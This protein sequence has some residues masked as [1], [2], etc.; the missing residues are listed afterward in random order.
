[1]LFAEQLHLLVEQTPVA[2]LLGD[3]YDGHQ[4][5]RRGGK[6]GCLPRLLL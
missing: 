3:G 1:M 5:A 4:E 2:R 6:I